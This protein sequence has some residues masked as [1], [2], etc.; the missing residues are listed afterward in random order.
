MLVKVGARLRLSDLNQ[1]E[2][3]IYY[4]L[5]LGRAPRLAP[6]QKVI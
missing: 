1:H 2:F 6:T 3:L 4:F 5:V